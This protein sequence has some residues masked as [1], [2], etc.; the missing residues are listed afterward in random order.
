MVCER[1]CKAGKD[2]GLRRFW[3]KN[4]RLS[5]IAFYEHGTPI[6]WQITWHASGQ[7]RKR[8]R[9]RNGK[10][11]HGSF[12]LLEG[13]PQKW[14]THCYLH[15]KEITKAEYEKAVAAGKVPALKTGKELE[16]IDVRP[17]PAPQPGASSKGAPQG[18]GPG[19]RLGA[20][21]AKAGVN[22]RPSKVGESSSR[23]AKAPRVRAGAPK[24][25]RRPTK[26]EI[27][28]DL[29]RRLRR[30]TLKRYL[31]EA[32]EA[33]KRAVGALKDLQDNMKAVNALIDAAERG[34][35]ER[36]KKNMAKCRRMRAKVIALKRSGVLGKL[37]GG[38]RETV[39]HYLDGY[40]ALY[41]RLEL[42]TQGAGT[43]GA[44]GRAAGG[45]GPSEPAS[46]PLVPK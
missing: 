11:W 19:Q 38:V 43:A 23:G 34:Q 20:V 16:G 31:D 44:P 2:H 21:G 1:Q 18:Q 37:P 3:H 40:L 36:V 22:G 33:L 32:D 8:G 13:Q 25:P 45:R 4:G 26:Q 27:L 6:G 30:G 15:G 24:A 14:S 29:R 28:A 12:D 39:T 9:Y 35:P 41:G 46:R 7:V 42:L 5:L 10:L 17:Q